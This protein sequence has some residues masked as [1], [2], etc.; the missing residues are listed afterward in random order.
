[1]GFEP[2]GLVAQPSS[3]TGVRPGQRQEP[4]TALVGEQ[5]LQVEV[6]QPH[7][8]DDDTVA[9]GH[10]GDGG[11]CRQTLRQVQAAAAFGERGQ[12]GALLGLGAGDVADG[13]HHRRGDDRR[14]VLTA[15]ELFGSGSER[16]GRRAGRGRGCVLRGLLRARAG[17]GQVHGGQVDDRLGHRPVFDDLDEV[18]CAAADAGIG[19]AQIAAV[20]GTAGEG[21]I[22][23]IGAA[24]G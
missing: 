24:V 3:A 16:A 21:R 14:P 9:G 17:F 10:L 4:A 15:H 11:L 8:A 22:E 13:Q 5:G 1:M 2:A 23:R 19:L 12:P 18:R 7:A 20:E 6:V